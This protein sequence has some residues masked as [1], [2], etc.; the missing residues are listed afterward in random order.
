MKKCIL[1]L[2]LALF[3][4]SS[5]TPA[6]SISVSVGGGDMANSASLSTN[7]N[8]D[9]STR[10]QEQTALSGSGIDQ[11]RTAS[12]TGNNL[13]DQSISGNGYSVNNVI[14]SSGSFS[15]TSSTAASG[16]NVGL[17]QNLAGTG[18]LSA[19]LGGNTA[20]GSSSQMTEVTNGA[21]STTQS[22]AAANGVYSGQSTELSGD[23][24]GIATSSSSEQNN[25]DIAGGFS[26]QGDLKADLSAMASGTSSV[27]GGASFLGVSVLDDEDMQML[28][29]G[30]IGFSVD[31]LTVQ[32]SGSIGSFGLSATN[33]DNV[34]ASDIGSDTSELLTG[35]AITSLGGRSSAYSLTGRKWVQKNP[36]IKMQLTAD[37][38]F[39][40][41]GLTTAGALAAITAATN[42]WDA[43][44]NQNLFSDSGASLTNARNWKLDGVNDIAF[45]PYARGCTAL[46]SSGTWYQIR[47][48]KAG[49][50]YPII[51][52]DLSFNSN[53]RWSTSGTGGYDF[54][55]VVLHELGHSIGLGDL[56]GRA[57]YTK[58][59][60][61]V[62]HYY[63]GVKRTLGNGDET[64]VWKMYG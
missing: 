53:Y 7:Y 44:T 2:A 36:Q 29:S 58:D 61:Q 30:D 18:D 15:T 8:L 14:D 57:A 62:M 63:T 27:G 28:A 38:N 32:T 4:C 22:L 1:A 25:V 37:T 55:S 40:R 51:E 9:S 60:Q 42:T 5:M 26:G 45:K 13:I 6:L 35:P 48:V 23:S 19:S 34:I 52:S 43:A 56:Y 10:L 49:Q 59:T 21:L 33:E 3:L 64:G 20:L 12:G 17:S 11:S 47:G 16:N 41:T 54:Q 46:A 31:G 24:G 39:A 50:Y